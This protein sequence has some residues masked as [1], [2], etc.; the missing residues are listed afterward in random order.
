MK[1]PRNDWKRFCDGRFK[2]KDKSSAEHIAKNLAG[3]GLPIGAVY[4][5]EKCGEF[6]VGL[7][8]N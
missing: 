2:Y 7:R 8:K 3:R 1:R 4:K 6:H 5:C